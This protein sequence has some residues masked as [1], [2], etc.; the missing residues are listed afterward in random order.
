M[1]ICCFEEG[2]YLPF[3]FGKIRS[4]NRSIRRNGFS[5]GLKGAVTSVSSAAPSPR[6]DEAGD[7]H[8][9]VE[10][11]AHRFEQGERPCLRRHRRD[12]SVS[13]RGQGDEAVVEE[14]GE[15]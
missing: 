1:L 14:I 9:D 13:R 3:Y 12:I 7:E 11:A 4:F 5:P 10:H 2:K 15:G 8:R 6:S